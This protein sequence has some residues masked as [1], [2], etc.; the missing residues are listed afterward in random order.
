MLKSIYIRNYALIEETTLNFQKGMTCITGEP[1]AGKSILL[2]ALGLV[3]GERANS[4]A[5]FDAEKKSIIEAT[6]SF[7]DEPTDNSLIS[8]FA[9]ND[10]DY[11]DDSCIIRREISAHGKSR[12]FINDSPVGLNVVKNL[13]T[14]L[15]DIQTQ[16]Q[17]FSLSDDEQQ[18]KYLDV[19][20]NDT[21]SIHDYKQC[22]EKYVSTC[23]ALNENQK[24]FE[25]NSYE[26]DFNVFLLNELEEANLI[27]DEYEQLEND[28]Q[29]LNNSEHIREKLS[30]ALYIISEQEVSNLLHDSRELT[31]LIS[32]IAQFI[33]NGEDL[34][35][36]IS[37]IYIEL[38]DISNEL[39]QALDSVETNPEKL[40][41]LEERFDMLNTLMK[42]H[43]VNSINELIEIR[44]KLSHNIANIS[45]NKDKIN[46][47]TKEKAELELELKRKSEK[48]TQVREKAAKK[49]SSL[50]TKELQTLGIK[51]NTFIISIKTLDKFLPT[52]SN[53]A[54]FLFS[55]N[56]GIPAGPV[57]NVASGGE[58][59]RIMLAL[60]TLAATKNSIKTIIFD[61]IDSG[62]SGYTASAVAQK[63]QSLS[64]IHQVI[65]I[66]HLPQIAAKAQQQYQVYKESNEVRTLSKV[67][68]LNYDERVETIA[69]MI[70]GTKI[71]QDALNNARFL[72]NESAE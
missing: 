59:S 72:I 5:C 60:S 55:A 4:S 9:D 8:F 67:K 70:S 65:A 27:A 40:N 50:I 32:S 56:I 69:S 42:K 26:Y 36:R 6:F 53:V 37:S 63:M 52:G 20:V 12:C 21:S 13:C 19:F 35:Q 23:N 71:N 31:S 15:L 54:E 58:L 11:D 46:S 38:K 14:K 3:L 18:L 57:F 7:I 25:K 49:L 22:F 66:T 61:E 39:S 28:I 47:L 16:Y 24:L 64:K 10:L 68:L 43:K 44:E 30:A 48:L 1:G 41:Q 33:N 29:R 45:I 34:N 62:I 17:K 2:D 51:D